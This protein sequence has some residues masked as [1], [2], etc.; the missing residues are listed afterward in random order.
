LKHFWSEQDLNKSWLLSTAEMSLLKGKLYSGRLVFSILLKHYQL[1]GFFPSE[2]SQTPK[3]V[4]KFLSHQI[5]IDEISARD[6]FANKRTIR[7]YCYEIRSF[8]KVNR[9]DRQARNLFMDWSLG[10]LFPEALNNQQIDRSS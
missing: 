3:R 2:V 5:G 1:T 4:V 9:F 7:D 8:L 10:S 6:L